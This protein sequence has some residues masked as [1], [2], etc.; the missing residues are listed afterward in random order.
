VGPPDTV[1]DGEHGLLLDAGTGA[2]RLLT[3]SDLV[4]GVTALDVV[5]THFHLDHVCGLLYL[6]ALLTLCELEG[7]PRVWAPGRWLYDTPSAELLGL[8][9]TGS[10]SG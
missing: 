10:R 8:G 4:D 6:P 9:W 5:L 3:D 1:R 2:R 7:H